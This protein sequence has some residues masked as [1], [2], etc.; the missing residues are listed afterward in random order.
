M[1]TGRLP[2][3][4]CLTCC[5]FAAVS[6]AAEQTVETKPLVRVIDLNVGESREVRLCN[7]Q[8]VT[9]KLLD[10]RE[11]RDSVRDAVRVARVKVA[12]NG[13]TVELTSATYHLPRQVGDVQIDCSITQGYSGR[14]QS[15]SGAD[16][17]ADG[18]PADG[19]RA[20]P[21]R[22]GAGCR[23]PL[24]RITA[25]DA[26]SLRTV[27]ANRCGRCSVPANPPAN[28]PLRKMLCPCESSRA[29]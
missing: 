28:P 19:D 2:W 17:P 9:V 26:L 14:G 5:L 3:F 10:L 27:P 16:G 11:Q 1:M 8:S 20:S 15:F 13:E 23:I 21:E 24:L 29:S 25:E 22:G 18:G 6:V 12:I 4:S 7:E